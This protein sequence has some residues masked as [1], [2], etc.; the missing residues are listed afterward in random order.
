M[1]NCRNKTTDKFLWISKKEEEEKRKR[2]S[3]FIDLLPVLCGYMQNTL[4]SLQTRRSG[5]DKRRPVHMVGVSAITLRSGESRHGRAECQGGESGQWFLDKS[6][7]RSRC[8]GAQRDDQRAAVRREDVRMETRS[9]EQS[10]R[11]DG[12]AEDI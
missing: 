5:G 9:A 3:P 6:S 12:G 4:R 8:P 2:K 10:C 7:V 1:C 11:R